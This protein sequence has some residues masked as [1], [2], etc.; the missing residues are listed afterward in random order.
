MRS[1]NYLCSESAASDSQFGGKRSMLS[2]SDAFCSSEPASCVRS[3]YQTPNHVTGNVSNSSTAQSPT[4]V[5]INDGI[6]SENTKGKK[7]N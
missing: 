5:I 6:G 7:V 4:A 1:N 3:Q 2:G